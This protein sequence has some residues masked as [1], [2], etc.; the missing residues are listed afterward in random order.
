MYW[1]SL[2][3]DYGCCFEAK[4]VLW[5]ICT[6]KLLCTTRISISLVSL[7]EMDRLGICHR[8]LEKCELKM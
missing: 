7:T 8:K 5:V 1:S 4:R 2:S 3:E 6:G